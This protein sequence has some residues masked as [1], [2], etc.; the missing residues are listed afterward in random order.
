MDHD[1][2]P[3]GMNDA[4]TAMILESLEFSRASSGTARSNA[5]FR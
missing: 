4:P 3:V 2:V 1:L 5:S